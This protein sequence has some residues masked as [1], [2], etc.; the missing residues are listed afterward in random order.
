MIHVVAVLLLAVASAS[1]HAQTAS[2]TPKKDI[3]VEVLATW[4]E[5]SFSSQLQAKADTTYLDIRLRMKRIW[6]ARTD[7]YWFVVEQAVATSQEAPYR[8]RVYNVRRVEENMIESRTFTWKDPSRVKGAWKDTTLV[9]GLTPSDLVLRRGCEVYL[10]L[11]AMHYFGSTHG[12]ACSSDLRGASY[13][14][15]EVK[16]YRDRIISWDRGFSADNQQVWG[17]TKGGYV[18][19]RQ[20]GW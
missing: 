13:A 15:S 8:Q 11:D 6:H 12:T 7:G 20:D 17:A 19:V 1:V 5:G 18:F 4:L 14:T 3:D 9:D 2:S 16:I 10:Q